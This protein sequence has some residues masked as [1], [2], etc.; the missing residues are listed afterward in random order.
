MDRHEID[1]AGRARDEELLEPSEAGVSDGGGSEAGAAGEG[2]EE[3]LVGGGG[4]GGAEVRLGAEVGLVEGEE[5]LGACGEGGGGGGGPGLGVLGLRAPEHGHVFE[6]AVEAGRSRAPVVGP[7]DF[8]RAV[9][10]AG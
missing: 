5:V 9:E 1:G 4:R 3:G 10:A 2:L 8:V 6:G 7:G